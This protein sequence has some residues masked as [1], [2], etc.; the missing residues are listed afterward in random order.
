MGIQASGELK[1]AGRVLPGPCPAAAA[2]TG[3]MPSLAWPC[4]ALPC[5]SSLSG[6]SQPSWRGDGKQARGEEPKVINKNTPEARKVLMPFTGW[7]AL[8]Q[9]TL[10]TLRHLSLELVGQTTLENRW[11]VV[12]MV[13]PL[14]SMVPQQRLKAKSLCFSDCS[15]SSSSASGGSGN[16]GWAESHGPGGQIYPGNRGQDC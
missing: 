9:G 5:L 7:V 14:W 13:A 2:A 8:V 10:F 11:R 1:G 6:I 15:R 16:R 4:P 12:A 3:Q